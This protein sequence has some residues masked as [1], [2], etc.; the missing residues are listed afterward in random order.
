MREKVPSY[1]RSTCA[2]PVL[3]F[4]EKTRHLSDT[5]GEQALKALMYPLVCV[6]SFNPLES[7]YQNQM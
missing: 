6:P 5:S 2:I 3:Y 7:E 4:V 1:Y